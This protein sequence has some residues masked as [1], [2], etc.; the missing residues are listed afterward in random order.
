MT[1]TPLWIAVQEDK[2]I[3]HHSHDREPDAPG[4]SGN[5]PLFDIN[6]PPKPENLA[7]CENQE[8]SEEDQLETA[9]LVGTCDQECSATKDQQQ[10]DR[11]PMNEGAPA[12]QDQ[13]GGHV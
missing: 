9:E 7:G 13:A 5:K 10:N 2:Q 1:K 4:S 3:D 6:Q 11:A 8:Q 12:N